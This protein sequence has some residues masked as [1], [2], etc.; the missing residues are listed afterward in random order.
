MLVGNIETSVLVCPQ[1]ENRSAKSVGGHRPES[2][3]VDY[4]P[5]DADLVRKVILH[6]TDL[7][8]HSRHAPSKRALTSRSDRGLIAVDV[9]LVDPMWDHE[10]DAKSIRARY[11]S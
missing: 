10:L 8:E 6:L 11:I 5:L 7:T 3:Y 9:Q 2:V 4:R 1:C